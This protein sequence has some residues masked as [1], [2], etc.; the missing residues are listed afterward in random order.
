LVSFSFVPC[1]V[2]LLIYGFGIFFVQWPKEKDT[3]AINQRTDNTVAKRKSYQSHKS[4]DRQY[5][6]VCPLIYGFGIFFFWPLYCL[7]FD[8]W[9]WYIF[10]LAIVLSVL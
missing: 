4:K 8:L 7:S 3:K 2:C 9:L 6:I 5:N 1:I 10:L